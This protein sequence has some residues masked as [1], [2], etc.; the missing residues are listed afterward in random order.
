MQLTTTQQA[1][2]TAP[3]NRKLFVE[4]AA[5]TGKTT[6]AV[7]R[8]LHL[9]RQ[10]VPASDILVMAPQRGLAEPYL[11][12]IRRGDVPPG[13]QVSVRTLGALA[14]ETVELFWPLVAAP[15]GFGQP[16]QPPTFLSLE[17]AQ[18]VMAHLV[19]P[20][21]DLEAYFSTIKLER[22]RLYSQI[23]DNLNKAA[24]V[25]FPHTEIGERLSSA[26]PDDEGQ[27]TAYRQ[28]QDCA[29]LFRQHCLE[30]NLLDFSLQIEIWRRYLWQ[31]DSAAFNYLTKKYTHLMIENVEEDT[32][33][34]HQ[35]LADWLGRCESALV[36]FDTDASYRRFL[37]AD[38]DT[39]YD[40]SAACDEIVRLDDSLV[41]ADDVAAL[42]AEIS[43]AMGQP[44]SAPASGDGR[45]A[46]RYETRRFYP[47]MLAWVAGQI[48]RLVHEDAVA[49][50]QI[51]VLAP[52][53]SDALR[54]TLMSRLRE[55]GVPARSHRP[56]RA[57]RE[58]PA[59]RCLLT[60]ARLAHPDWKLP[61]TAYDV[62][63]ALMQAIGDI[64][65]GDTMDLVRAQ[66]LAGAVYPDDTSAS[67]LARFEALPADT[68]SR[69]TFIIGERYETL[70][71]WL[72][73]YI[74]E[75]SRQAAGQRPRRKV[76]PEDARPDPIELDHFF[77][78]LFGEVLSQYGF[79][80]HGALDA[81]HIVGNLV[82]SAR[83]FRQ[84]VQDRMILPDDEPVG[85]EY[86]RMVADGVIANSYPLR[87]DPLAEPAVLI[88][89]A[90]TYLLNNEP[91]D[92]QF[93]LDIGSGGWSERLYQ[94]LTHPYVLSR[95]W[96]PGMKWTDDDEQAVRAR[97]LYSLLIGLV[98]RCRRG[99]YLGLSELGESGYESQGDL[100]GV[101]QRVL[102]RL[103]ALGSTPTI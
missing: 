9:L 65:P 10:G 36:I 69:I 90:Y 95:S 40:L 78:L 29:N 5:G 35:M 33:A 62:A 24:L 48:D 74:N 53:L 11:A 21:I 63:Y 4:G 41:M 73:D 56:S 85:R 98:R 19:R 17:S 79:G 16:D 66:L 94:P 46:L 82:D 39:A 26:A 43:A 1:I 25:G 71:R 47:E 37:S 45:A 51:V 6:A 60:L 101:V 83:H 102:R 3:L 103:A 91:V 76:S 57:L 84:T 34:T 54:F 89:P 52:F 80:F 28:V 61:P 87:D 77:S 18:Y 75:R 68:Q 67:R 42:G 72:E 58:E 100:L 27:R 31:P 92:Y 81:A 49:P 38:E 8:L 93:W 22:N 7:E 64:T 12:A 59:T 86:L 13:G 96:Q 32:P 50:D 20:K 14:L 55:L 99:V 2:V 23:I 97:V 44:A 88:A 15:A 70:R 30:H